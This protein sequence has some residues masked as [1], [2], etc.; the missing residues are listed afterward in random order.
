MKFGGFYH[1]VAFDVLVDVDV[2]GEMP[3]DVEQFIGNAPAKGQADIGGADFK[4]CVFFHGLSIRQGKA[5]VKTLISQA[6]SSFAGI[7]FEVIL[8]IE[9]IA[10]FFAE[11]H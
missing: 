3:V 7:W 6:R 10:F 11:I 1:S 4:Q 5:F 2:F 8:F 9:V